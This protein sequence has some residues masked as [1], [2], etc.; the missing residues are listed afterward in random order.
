MLTAEHPQT[1]TGDLCLP[2]WAKPSVKRC[3]AKTFAFVV[4][5]AWSPGRHPV[6]SGLQAVAPP[7]AGSAQQEA[8]SPT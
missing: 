1:E 5:G 7:P 2:Q 6:G 4:Q 3:L 8:Y